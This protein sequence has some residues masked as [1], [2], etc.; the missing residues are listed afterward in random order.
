[1][2]EVSRRSLITGIGCIIAAPAIVRASSLMK[3]KPGNRETT[4]MTARWLAEIEADQQARGLWK[5]E[6]CVVDR[7][8][9][10]STVKGPGIDL[11]VMR[12]LLRPGLLTIAPQH[13]D[14]AEK[15]MNG[16][17]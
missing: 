2:I 5:A 3:V 6:Y 8:G 14:I 7:T 11:N 17:V 12:E 1:M 9:L 16:D 13:E 15:W 4:E 10:W